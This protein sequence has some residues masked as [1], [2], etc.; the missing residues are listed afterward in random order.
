MVLNYADY[1]SYLSNDIVYQI[2]AL[3]KVEGT[4]FEYFAQDDFR[5]VLPTITIKVI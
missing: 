3:C 1:S 2:C 5:I 4:D